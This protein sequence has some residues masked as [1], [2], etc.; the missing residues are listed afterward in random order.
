LFKFFSLK[1]NAL[2]FFAPSQSI[3]IMKFNLEKKKELFENVF[4]VLKGVLKHKFSSNLI[5][6]ESRWLESTLTDFKKKTKLSLF[7]FK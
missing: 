1:S 5:I 7:F 6:Q 3:I 4:C 2:I